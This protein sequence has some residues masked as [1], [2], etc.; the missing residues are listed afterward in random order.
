MGCSSEKAQTLISELRLHEQVTVACVNSPSSI[1]LSGDSAA[2]EEV[3]VALEREQIFCRKLRVKVAYH[4]SHVAT[5]SGE[6]YESIAEIEP[7]QGPDG[8]SGMISSVSGEEVSSAMLGPVYW[9]ENFLSPVLFSDAVK[10]MVL[11]AGPGLDSD[12]TKPSQRVDVLVEIGPHSTLGGP[13]EQTLSHYRI[14]NIAYQS[15]LQRGS[16]SLESTLKLAQELFHQGVSLDMCMVNGDVGVN[17]QLLTDL[18]PYPWLH[19]RKYDAYPRLHRE[20]VQRKA[21]RKSLLGAQ[22]P[23]M[24]DRQHVWRGFVRLDEEPWLRGHM[25]GDTVV[26]PAA[27]MISMVL[28]AAQQLIGSGQRIHALR[29]RDVSVFAVMSIQE[30]QG[31]EVILTMR[32]YQSSTAG[33]S[34]GQTHSAWW[35]FTVSSASNRNSQLRDNSHGL[36]AIDFEEGRSEHMVN[37][38]ASIISER[39]SE[40]HDAMKELQLEAHMTTKDAFYRDFERGPGFRYSEIFRGLENLHTGPGRTCFDLRITDLGDTFSKGQQPNHRPFLVHPA[41][42]D[43]ILQSWVAATY[44]NGVT[45]CDKPFAPT[46]MGEMELMMDIPGNPDDVMTGFSISERLGFNEHKNDIF[47]FNKSLSK[48]YMSIVDLRVSEL[49][50]AAAGVA[51]EAHGA[52]AKFEDGEGPT[53]TSQIKWDYALGQLQGTEMAELVCAA[54]A[55]GAGAGLPEDRLAE[56][57]RM[58]LHEKPS[59]T[60]IELVQDRRA[61]HRAV[62]NATW[63]KPGLLPRGALPS[64]HVRYAVVQ[65]NVDVDVDDENAHHENGVEAA[66]HGAPFSLQVGSKDAPFP[67][68]SDNLSADLLVVPPWSLENFG[69]VDRDRVLNRFISLAKPGCILLLAANSRPQHAAVVSF[70]RSHGLQLLAEIPGK[71]DESTAV[72]KS[73]ETQSEQESDTIT[74]AQEFVILE[75]STSLT[76]PKEFSRMLKDTLIQ[77]GQLVSVKNWSVIADASSRIEPFADTF[78]ANSVISLLE[79]QQ[80]MLHDLSEPDFETL[81]S[82]I[83]E[84]DR[85]IWV[86]CGDDP[87]LYTVDG[88]ARTIANENTGFRFQILHLSSTGLVHGPSL[89]ARVM[90]NTKDNE[91]REVDGLLQTARLYKSYE[92]DRRLAYHYEDSTRIVPLTQEKSPHRLAIGRPGLL[93]T[94]HFVKDE[95]LLQPLADT[96]VEIQV[97]AS[98]IK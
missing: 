51:D 1:T 21:P 96:D 42:L 41:T 56:L 35:E 36:I 10:E 33:Q 60:V 14:Y 85:F 12:S 91:F 52:K 7:A 48:I 26:F 40:Y 92:G 34:P 2:I 57:I 82:I 84:S 28:E 65:T 23:T 71:M 75:P 32:P 59:A 29:L 72:Y 18:P 69:D 44:R 24:Q 98:G 76:G 47:L 11:P 81:R 77:Q 53:V 4:S 61:L 86:T 19:E 67:A 79:L 70:L 64:S 93:D 63:S 80:P 5:V 97:R 94:L 46:S 87:L 38:D 50:V 15:M 49:D 6:Y 39:L 89:A 16:S 13:I 66:V 58:V 31:T 3:A 83:R 73:P 45:W 22:V 17:C 88:F 54:T 95:R 9:L 25:V 37:E 27:G 62:V 68:E 74:S 43:S 20:L 30:G 55:S 78:G 90:R 8:P